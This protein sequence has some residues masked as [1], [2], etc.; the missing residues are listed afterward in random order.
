MSG[1][2]N[3]TLLGGTS[4]ALTSGNSYNEFQDTDRYDVDLIIGGSGVSSGASAL[5]CAN[6]RADCIAFVSPKENST[7]AALASADRDTS[8][9]SYLSSFGF[10]DSGSKKMYD[11]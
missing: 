6:E 11:K 5:N 4:T 8:Y 9:I 1:E 10:M 7:S 2:T 3:F